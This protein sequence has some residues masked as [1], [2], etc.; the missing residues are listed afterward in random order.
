MKTDFTE[1]VCDHFTLMLMTIL[2]MCT[3]LKAIQQLRVFLMR[4]SLSLQFQVGLFVGEGR[5]EVPMLT[6]IRFRVNYSIDCRLD[7]V[8]SLMFSGVFLIIIP[9]L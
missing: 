9:S 3:Y 8:I 7:R 5:G 4:I 1:Q 6:T 2:F